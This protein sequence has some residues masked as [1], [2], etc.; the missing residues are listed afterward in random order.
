MK[1]KSRNNAVGCVGESSGSTQEA[2]PETDNG[3][4]T[5]VE[6]ACNPSATSSSGPRPFMGSPKHGHPQSAFAASGFFF[7][8]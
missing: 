4:E 6:I 8:F 7:L 1:L 3:K 2:S 5:H